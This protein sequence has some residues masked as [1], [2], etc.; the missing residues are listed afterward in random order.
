MAKHASMI[1]EGDSMEPTFSAGDWLMGRWAKYKL[2]GLNRIKVGD[3]VV[4][5]RDEQPGIFYVKRISQTRSSGSEIPSIYL[6]SDNE[7]GTDSR[8]WGWLPITAVRAKIQFR[9]KRA[10]RMKKS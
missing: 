9:M 8:T 6:L 4:I 2:T 1:I 5:E 10:S 7:A 3:V